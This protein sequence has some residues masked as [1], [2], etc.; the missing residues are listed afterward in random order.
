MPV[1]N[2]YIHA[3]RADVVASIR[4]GQPM[5]A[6]ISKPRSR[7]LIYVY[8]QDKDDSTMCI[9]DGRE[10]GGSKSLDIGSVTRESS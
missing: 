10:T 9:Y 5:A 2:Y 6:Q 8:Y 7:S 3:N 1:D 4:W